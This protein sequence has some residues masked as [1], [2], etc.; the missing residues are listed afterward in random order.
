MLFNCVL[1]PYN[2]GRERI[3]GVVKKV[4]RDTRPVLR[5]DGFYSSVSSKTGRESPKE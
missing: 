3:V 1:L 2:E 4:R 5:L